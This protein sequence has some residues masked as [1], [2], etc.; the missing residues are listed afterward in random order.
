[1][2]LYRKHK[3]FGYVLDRRTNAKLER[4]MRL[5]MLPLSVAFSWFVVWVVYSV[6]V[7]LIGG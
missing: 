1:M 2:N 3:G 7:K 6:L 5:I 4:T